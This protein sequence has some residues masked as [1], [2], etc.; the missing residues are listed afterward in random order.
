MSAD[1]FDV[2][3]VTPNGFAPAYSPD[4]SKIAFIRNDG[5]DN[6]IWVMDA[7]GANAVQLTSNGADDQW[8]TWSADGSKIAF[9]SDLGG[10]Y[11]IYTINPAGGT[12]TPLTAG[13]G[14]NATPSWSPNGS[15]VAFTRMRD[16]R[17]E[18]YIMNADGTGQTRLTNAADVSYDPTWSPDGS[19]ILFTRGD[20]IPHIYVM[21]PDGSSAVPLTSSPSAADV[22]AAWSPDG[23]KI[24]FIRVVAE[25][26]DVFVMN[27]DGSNPTNITNSATISETLPDWQPIPNASSVSN[28]IQALIAYLEQLGLPKN[29]VNPLRSSLLN[30]LAA[31]NGNDSALACSYIADFISKTTAQNGKK[32]PADV[33]TDLIQR[34]RAIGELLGCTPPASKCY[35]GLPTPQLVL[36][37]TT[38]EEPNVRFEFN[39]SNFASF[40]NELFAQAPDLPP[41][42]LNTRASR[43]WV[44]VYDGDNNRLFGFCAFGQASDLNGVWF[45]IAKDKWPAQAYIKLTDRRCNITYTSN[46]VNLAGII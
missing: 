2:Q 25:T 6:E 7:D 24:V 33:A 40:P 21:N 20:A 41:C 44:D 18:V 8:P 31:V 46:K 11:Q 38:I 4:G 10:V 43:T 12:P 37:S 14:P 39:V 22:G 29:T 1:G 13:A 35:I 32:F 19:K 16:G 45:Q 17:Q 34:A 3:T 9:G 42:G 30:A 27:A 5:L 36:E 28:Q 15:K 23:S 26:G